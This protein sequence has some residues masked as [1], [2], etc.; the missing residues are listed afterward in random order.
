MKILDRPHTNG[1]TDGNAKIV[2]EAPPPKR[3]NWRPPFAAIVA[4]LVAIVLA[5][6]SFMLLRPHAALAV[7]TQPVTQGTLSANVTATGTV[8][9]Q[10]TVNVGTQV[11][12][13]ISQLYVD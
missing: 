11:S 6:G 13:T 12:G 5:L 9:P 7:V 2:F 1:H 3:R 10:N 4:A 8:N